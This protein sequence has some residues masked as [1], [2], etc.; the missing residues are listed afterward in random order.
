MNNQKG[1]KRAEAFLT[2]LVN[3]MIERHVEG[4][5]CNYDPRELATITQGGKPLRTMARRVDGAFPSVVNPIAIWEIKEYYYTTTFGSRIADGVY[6][7]LLDGMELEE[8]REH[9]SINVKHYL[10]VDS[11]L[12]WWKCGKS[13]I[14]R[15]FDMLHMGYAD[16]ILFGRE[17]IEEMPRI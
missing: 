6:E 13:Y 4:L 12:T 5:P 8:L 10:M 16:K 17:V 2:A 15:M 3:M 14:C 11:H 1:E 7:T 9:E